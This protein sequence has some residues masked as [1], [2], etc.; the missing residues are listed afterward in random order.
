MLKRLFMCLGDSNTGKS[1]LTKALQSSFGEYVGTFNAECF[2]HKETS[3]DEAQIMRWAL[4]MRFKR[5][6]FSNELSTKGKL[7]GSM[8][9]K[10]SSG[11]DSLV[12]RTHGKEETS[13]TPH[14]I[15]NIF[16]ND[17]NEI[18]PYDDAL[19]NRLRVIPYTKVYVDENPKE[20]LTTKFKQTFI[21]I[22]LDSFINFK[23][24]G[25]IKEPDAVLS[26]RSEWVSQDANVIQKFLESYNITNDDKDFI[27]SA[28]IKEWVKENDVGISDTKFAMELKKYCLKNKLDNV[29][30]KYK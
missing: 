9:K 17:I 15:A 5:I 6:I 19:Q 1:T 26:A 27:K 13:F 8:M 25:E 3:Q 30:N 4:L 28:D 24:N 2:N 11:G 16:A 7:N 23:L 14:F 18:T 29:Y 22:M 12:G 20:M 10:V 21:R